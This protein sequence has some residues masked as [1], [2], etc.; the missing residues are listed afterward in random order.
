MCKYFIKYII[1]LYTYNK[2]NCSYNIHKKNNFL[3]LFFQTYKTEYKD[4]DSATK[5]IQR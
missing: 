1:I 5:K 3:N 2:F 4:T